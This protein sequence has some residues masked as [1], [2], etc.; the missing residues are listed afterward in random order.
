[1]KI[2]ASN[3]T[4]GGQHEFESECSTKTTMQCSFRSVLDGASEAQALTA[5]PQTKQT[6]LA[7]RDERICLMLEQLIAEMLALI[8]GQHRAKLTDM[9]GVVATPNSE[10]AGKAK[11]SAPRSREMIWESTFTE[12][13]HESE[14]SRFAASGEVRTAD[15]RAIDFRLDLA[16]CRDFRSERK[17]IDQGVVEM[18]DPLVINFD[19]K[20]A[21]LG[22]VRFDFD[23]DGDGKRESIHGLSGNRGFLAID[24]NGDG[25]INDGREL[26]G[27]RSG[28]GF[29]DLAKLDSDGNHWID[30]ADPAFAELRV[31]ASGGDGKE[32]MVGLKD[33]GVGAL[34][35]GSAETPFSLKDDDNRLRG[36]VRAS[37][38]YLREDGST[39]TLQQVDLAV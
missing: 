28:D 18:R 38:I 4:L 2:E 32:R 35:L 16:M 1:M 21:E 9:S 29:A 34:Y 39:G 12:S 14:R 24:R 3:V 10:P 31:W 22:S 15:G 36:E 27:T 33:K 13:I 25:C 37:G 17:Q 5:L 6:N 11:N 30:E 8:S 7:A 23:L 26:F 19:G 20:A